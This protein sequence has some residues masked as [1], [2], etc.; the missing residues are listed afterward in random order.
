MKRLRQTRCAGAWALL[1]IALHCSAALA[2]EASVSPARMAR[3]GTVDQ[4]FQSYN[5][6]MVEVT[7]G[8]FWKPYGA[9][10]TAPSD[11]SADNAGNMPA[12][13]NPGLFAYREPIDLSNRRLRTLAAALAPAYMRV[14]GTW[15]NSTYFADSDET[16]SA[17]P[18]G[19]SAVLSRERWKGVIDFARAASAEIVTS[20]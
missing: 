13:S 11:R 2:G 6:E 18:D 20:M 15:A 17:P 19:F 8:R 1:L 3:I 7:G 14:S 4:R 9:S 16:P 12:G 5:V 10:A